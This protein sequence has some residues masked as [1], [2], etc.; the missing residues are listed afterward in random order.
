MLNV[1]WIPSDWNRQYPVMNFIS[2]YILGLTSS[3]LVYNIY[4]MNCQSHIFGLKSLKY[5][6]CWLFM[7]LTVLWQNFDNC[8]LIFNCLLI[9]TSTLLNFFLLHEL[10]KYPNMQLIWSY[11]HVHTL[12]AGLSFTVEAVSFSAFTYVIPTIHS[13]QVWV[14]LLKLY[15]FLQLHTSSQHSIFDTHLAGLSVTVGAVSFSAV[16]YVVPIFSIWYPLGRSECHCWSCILFCSYICCPN[17]QCLVLD[18][19]LVQSFQCSLIP[20]LVLHNKQT[21]VK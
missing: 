4:L 5:V 9:P 1:A 19:R 3:F 2:F 12:L 18:N 14:S 6:T 20:N 15:P 11:V 17:I 13:W 16:T 8:N 10:A 21:I 7:D